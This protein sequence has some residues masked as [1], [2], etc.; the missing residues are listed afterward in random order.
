MSDINPDDCMYNTE[1]LL[2][3]SVGDQTRLQLY[4]NFD[5]SPLLANTMNIN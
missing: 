2:S 5:S 3:P 1:T 4:A